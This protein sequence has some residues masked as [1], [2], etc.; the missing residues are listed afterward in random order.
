MGRIAYLI[1]VGVLLS[2]DHPD[3]EGY[4]M[5]YD[6]KYGYFD[7]NQFYEVDKNRAIDYVTQYVNEG[8]D[9]TYGVVL[10]E[11]LQEDYSDGD[12]YELEV[13]NDYHIDDIIFSMAKI[14][15]K[16]EENFIK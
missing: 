8:V 13:D 15:G 2:K 6:R 5:V 12:I 3:Y 14:N 11:V 9:K 1:D 10:K 4:N 16:I 7:E